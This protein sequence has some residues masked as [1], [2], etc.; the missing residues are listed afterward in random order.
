MGD[1]L[2]AGAACLHRHRDD[3]R[4]SGTF[5]TAGS[6]DR[7]DCGCSPEAGVSLPDGEALPELSSL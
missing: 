6:A 3:Q 5:G 7:H 2:P 4:C 1:R